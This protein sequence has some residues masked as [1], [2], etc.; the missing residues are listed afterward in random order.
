MFDLPHG[1]WLCPAAQLNP[2]DS[3]SLRLR[4]R[5][6]FPRCRHR[7]APEVQVI[8]RMSSP[9]GR[10]SGRMQGAAQP[11]SSCE[12][13]KAAV[14]AAAVRARQAPAACK[15]A[16]GEAA[17]RSRLKSH[18]NL[19]SRHY[20]LPPYH[21]RPLPARPPAVWHEATTAALTATGYTVSEHH[22]D[23]GLAQL[24]IR[25]TRRPPYPREDT[26]GRGMVAVVSG[27]RTRPT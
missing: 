11:A 9:A 4:H 22:I 8:I 7:N 5:A 19:A 13:S 1:V 21:H 12:L 20:F 2:S 18:A 24:T 25:D 17:A 3:E 26:T 14:R 6:N 10:C 23:P 15:Q 16:A 27:R